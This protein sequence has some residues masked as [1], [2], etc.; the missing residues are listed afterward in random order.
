MNEKVL[1]TLEFNKVLE[2]LAE[3]A[4]SSPGKERCLSLTPRTSLAEITKLGI[5]TE[6]ALKRAI[7]ETPPDFRAVA[8]FSGILSALRAEAMLGMGELLSLGFFLENTGRIKAYGEELPEEDSLSGFFEG[9]SP[10]KPLSQE[11]LR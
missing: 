7:Q 10:L 4:S 6:D 11:I 1:K 3:E 8:D 9:L 2:M 5:Q